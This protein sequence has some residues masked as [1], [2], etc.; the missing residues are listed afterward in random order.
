MSDYNKGLPH[1]VL[2]YDKDNTTT[3]INYFADKEIFRITIVEGTGQ[4]FSHVITHDIPKDVWG[5]CR[6]LWDEVFLKC[7]ICGSM[8]FKHAQR[9]DMQWLYYCNNFCRPNHNSFY[10][11]SVKSP[12]PYQLEL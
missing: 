6:L 9:G 10:V 4:H 8:M 12:M 3:Y 5:K 11:L 7:P 2:Q 1:L